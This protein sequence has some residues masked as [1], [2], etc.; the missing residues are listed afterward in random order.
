MVCLTDNSSLVTNLSS[1][2][3]GDQIL[4][5]NG[6][7]MAEYK[8]WLGPPHTE[9]LTMMVVRLVLLHVV[10]VLKDG[11]KNALSPTGTSFS[12]LVNN[13]QL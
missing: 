10:L 11:N 9:P 5:E 6:R 7:V 3:S 8:F 4:L 12:P 1:V 13:T 2:S